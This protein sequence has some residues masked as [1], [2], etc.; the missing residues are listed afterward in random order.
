M[1]NTFIPGDRTNHGSKGNRRPCSSTGRDEKPNV[2]S[3][4]G[5][6]IGCKTFSSGVRYVTLSEKFKLS[7]MESF[8]GTQ[9]PSEFLW[10]H[11]TTVRAIGGDEMV[12][13]NY[14]PIVLNGSAK[15]WLFNQPE[16]SICIA[17]VKPLVKTCGRLLVNL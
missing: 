3:C 2:Q 13:A 9:N 16:S 7:N 4:L 8:D 6:Y 17:F 14:S 1:F 11:T 15:T 10:I 5:P 12:M